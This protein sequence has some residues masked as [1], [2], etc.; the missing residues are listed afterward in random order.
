MGDHQKR[1]TAPDRW[2]IPKKAKK[3]VVKTAPGP[4]SSDAMPVAVWLRDHAGFAGNMKE[5]RQILNQRDVILNGRY[6]RDPKIGI[7]VF[8]VISIPRISKHYLVVLGTNGRY[9]TKEITPEQ[10]AVR[11]CK[12]RN[13]RMVPGGKIQLSLRYGAT[14]LSDAP[15]R[16]NDSIVVTLGDPA[17]PEV[18][19]FQI[20]EHYPFEVG[21]YALVIGGKHGGKVGKIVAIEKNPGNTPNRVILE[22][23]G[24]KERFDTVVDYTFMVGK[25]LEQAISWGASA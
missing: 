13:R 18:K 2:G 17:N 15:V 25:T 20:L 19:R 16:P 24:T 3:F 10:A 5:V 22:E 12:V 21:N 4:H 8:D 23:E 11:L 1:L 9:V 14:L 6:C 7:G